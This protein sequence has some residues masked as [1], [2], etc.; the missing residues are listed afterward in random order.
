MYI[1][2]K[3]QKNHLDKCIQHANSI[4]E[5]IHQNL[6]VSLAKKSIFLSLSLFISSV[7]RSIAI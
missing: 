7:H 5:S 3:T 4:V 2:L 6:F 1:K